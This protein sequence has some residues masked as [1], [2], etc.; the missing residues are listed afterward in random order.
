MGTWW[1]T[2]SARERILLFL[3]VPSIV[4]GG[5]FMLSPAGTS[6]RKLLSEREARQQYD[7]KRA[8]KLRKEDDIQRLQP[9][10]DGLT[11]K[12]APEYVIP[13]AIKSLQQTAKAAGIHIREIKPLRT[14]RVAG[15]TKV[16]LSVRF[17]CEFSKTVPF[18][19]HAEDP[20]GKL[21]V[22][23]LNVTAPDTKSRIVDVEAHVAFFTTSTAASATDN[24]AAAGI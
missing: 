17:S 11:Y 22:E 7:E 21:V 12:E 10:I 19:Y 24:V 1:Q 6:G 23:R 15:I 2:R 20:A 9:E 5:L 13:K 3:L 16:P 18:L 8:E 14:R 4:I